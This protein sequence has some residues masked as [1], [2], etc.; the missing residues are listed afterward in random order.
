MIQQAS[1]PSPGLVLGCRATTAP[2]HPLFFRPHPLPLPPACPRSSMSHCLQDTRGWQ[3]REASG[4]SLG[5]LSQII[6]LPQGLE[7]T[8]LG[9]QLQQRGVLHLRTP[10]CAPSARRY[11]SKLYVSHISIASSCL[12]RAR[13][14]PLLTTACS[15]SYT[16][17]AL[18]G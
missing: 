13:H 15:S 6:C 7:L 3:A 8:R 18:L 2:R 14:Q 1:S 5:G 12:L 17:A 16:L 9:I 4:W 11:K 10:T